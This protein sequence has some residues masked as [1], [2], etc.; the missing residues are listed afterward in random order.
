MVTRDRVRYGTRELGSGHHSTRNSS[1][2]RMA[3][4]YASASHMRSSFSTRASLELKAEC[5][6][7][8]SRQAMALRA[9]IG[10]GVTRSACARQ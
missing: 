2:P 10:C 5:V 6:E 3:L 7:T 4:R 8:L 9:R 1:P